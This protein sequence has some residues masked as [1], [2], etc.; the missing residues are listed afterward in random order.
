MVTPPFD[1][2]SKVLADPAEAGFFYLIGENSVVRVGPAG[3]DFSATAAVRSVF[4]RVP[5]N[6]SILGIVTGDRLAL[7]NTYFQSP[8]ILAQSAQQVW[9]AP[10]DRNR[11]YLQRRVSGVPLFARTDDAGATWLDLPYPPITSASPLLAIDPRQ[12]GT[13]YIGSI[14][15]GVHVSR[16]GGESWARVEDVPNARICSLAVDYRGTLWAGSLNGLNGFIGR[17][18]PDATQL[19]SASVIGGS[20]PS[21]VTSAVPAAE[22]RYWIAG[23]TLSSDFPVSGAPLSPATRP[24]LS[25]FAGLFESSAAN[26]RRM[27][28]SDPQ[29]VVG[30][31]SRLHFVGSDGEDIVLMAYDPTTGESN[32]AGKFGG[33]RFEGNARVAL[34][35]DGRLRIAGG[36]A[37]SDF[38]VTP[39]AAEPKTVELYPDVPFAGIS[40]GFLLWLS[41]S[42]P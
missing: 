35:T 10:S 9:V 13:L 33:S 15:D 14:E 7:M 37:S 11:F 3:F 38:P 24:G 6:D 1:R 28:L 32:V 2:F 39:N 25:G 18:S 26:L 41:R 42:A 20:G 21:S 19:L 8:R 31:D 36:T 22:G 27:A 34:G 16:D 12:S 30:P 5:D 29:F 40:D 4:P 17:F 23:T